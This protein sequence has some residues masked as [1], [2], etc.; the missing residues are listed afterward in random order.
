MDFQ[1]RKEKMMVFDKIMATWGK[2]TGM[3]YSLSLLGLSNEAS[4]SHALG[5]QKYMVLNTGRPVEIL[6]RLW[7]DSREDRT[8]MQKKV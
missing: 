7:M 8:S 2:Q 5:K 3:K 6:G 4:S 1:P